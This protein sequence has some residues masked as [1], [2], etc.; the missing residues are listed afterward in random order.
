VLL[1]ERIERGVA[2]VPR[3]DVENRE[4]G[5]RRDADVR[6]RVT[7]SPRPQ[8]RQIGGRD[9]R[10][11]IWIVITVYVAATDTRANCVIAR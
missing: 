3:I 5:A 9:L 7:L 10:P 1:D 2:A 6:V 11:V 8:R 4:G